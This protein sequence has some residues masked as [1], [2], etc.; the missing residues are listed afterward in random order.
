MALPLREFTRFIWRM[1]H[2][3]PCGRRSLDQADQPE[4]IDPPI[5]RYSDYIHHHHLLLFSPKADTQFTIPR[6][7]EGWV[8]LAGWLHTE[9]LH[10]PADCHPS[11]YT[12]VLVVVTHWS[13]SLNLKL[14]DVEPSYYLSG[15]LSRVGK[16]F[17]YITSHQGQLSLAIP[18]WT[19]TMS[20]SKNWNIN[21]HTAWCTSPISEVSV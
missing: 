17:H 11:K 12:V 8:D 19:S 5:G 4:P 15:W 7:A 1:Q 10:L 16:I 14:L 13:Q 2:P 21:K 18:P 9:M 3:A 20:A 6:M